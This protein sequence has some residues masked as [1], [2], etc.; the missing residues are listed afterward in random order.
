MPACGHAAHAPDG[1]GDA[2]DRVETANTDRHFSMSALPHAGQRGCSLPRTRTS[3][4]W[5][6]PE[7]SYSNSGMADS[8]FAEGI[9]NRE[10]SIG[11]L[12]S[13]F[14]SVT[15]WMSPGLLFS[16]TWGIIRPL[17]SL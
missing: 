6:H 17:T 4:L 11:T 13:T 1:A 15:F 16:M 3:N 2:A 14:C 12:I 7:H 10:S 8:H 9:L 5:W